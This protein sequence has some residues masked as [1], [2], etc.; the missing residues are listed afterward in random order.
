MCA[1]VERDE[2]KARQGKEK[3]KDVDI[4]IDK[5]KGKENDE[6]NN[7]DEGEIKNVLCHHSKLKLVYFH[8]CPTS[9]LNGSRLHDN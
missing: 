2:T 8:C 5:E 4:G 9:V 3:N 7:N 6:D 1:L